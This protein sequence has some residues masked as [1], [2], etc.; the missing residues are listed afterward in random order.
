MERQKRVTFE[1]A[2]EVET[3]GCSGIVNQNTSV[4]SNKDKDNLERPTTDSYKDKPMTMNK[5]SVDYCKRG[6]SRESVN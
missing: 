3:C 4:Y 1:E 2:S 5:F 6:T